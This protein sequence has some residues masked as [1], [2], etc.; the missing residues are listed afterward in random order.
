MEQN[1]RVILQGEIISQEV[2]KSYSDTEIIEDTF[3][4]IRKTTNMSLVDERIAS[5]DASAASIQA[6]KDELLNDKAQVI[7]KIA[8]A[9]PKP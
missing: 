4:V 5:L 2:V 9:I 1:Q 6:S 3:I 8:S 7:S